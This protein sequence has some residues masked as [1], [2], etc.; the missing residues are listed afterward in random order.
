MCQSGIRLPRRL[1]ACQTSGDGLLGLPSASP[2][3]MGLATIFLS[4]QHHVHVLFSLSR[5]NVLDTLQI[6]VFVSVV[7]AVS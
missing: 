1:L 5:P 6:H 4:F 7:C 3:G 2:P